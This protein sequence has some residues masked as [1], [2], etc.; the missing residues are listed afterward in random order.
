MSLK[1][2]GLAVGLIAAFGASSASAS[3]ASA[4]SVK[5]FD[6]SGQVV[7]Q[8]ITTCSLS[9]SAHYGNI[10]TAYH[11]SE[12]A[13]C[14]LGQESHPAPI[15]PGTRVTAYTLP[16]FLSIQEACVRAVC[17]SKEATELDYIFPY[18]EYELGWN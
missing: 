3:V 17:A 18:S 10:H 13:P 7:G 8:Q 1:G 4:S 16:G 9:R 6:E 2:L 11:I 12:S 5:Y 14:T 15:V